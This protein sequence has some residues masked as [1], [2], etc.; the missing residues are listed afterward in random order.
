MVAILESCTNDVMQQQQ[1][2]SSKVETVKLR[3]LYR[4]YCTVLNTSPPLKIDQILGR[5]HVENITIEMIW[6]SAL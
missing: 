5:L 1:Q 6:Y 4:I 3:Y 2:M